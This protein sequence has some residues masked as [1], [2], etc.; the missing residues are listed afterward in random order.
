MINKKVAE[1]FPPGEF[2]KEELE[3]RNWSQT[4]L[5]EIIGRQPNV[6]SE[7]IMGKRSITPETANALGDAFGT[8]AQYWMNLETSYQL[9][10]AEDTDNAIVRRSKLYQ[11]APIKEMAKRHWIEPSENV[12]V[13]EKRVMRF[14]EIKS[15]DEP[16]IFDHAAR[17]GVQAILPSHK[18]WFFRAKQL[19]QAVYAKNFS[20]HSFNNGLVKLKNLLNS[21]PE[22]RH[23]PKILSEAGI[24]FLIIEPLPQ[25]RIDGVTFWLDKQSPVIVLSLRFDRIDCFWYTLAHELGHIKR[26]DGLKSK[27]IIDTELMENTNDY[28]QIVETKKAEEYANYFA[29]DFLLT[30]T[31]LNNFIDR[32]RPLYGRQKIVNFANRIKVHPGIVVGQLQFRKEIPYSAFRQMLEK[33]KNIIIPSSLTDGWKQTIPLFQDKEIRNGYIN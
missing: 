1:V 13:L 6:I 28:E 21:V 16:I 17:K 19:A 15:I 10:R 24:R 29:T 11:I 20:D 14:F 33:V 7:L 4:E 31:E 30:H 32:V 2:I 25:T 9:W 12:D 26:R 8:S 3:A 23:V 18:A 5:A 22:I 27:M